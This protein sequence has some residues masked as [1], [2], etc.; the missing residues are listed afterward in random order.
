M[1]SRYAAFS[2]TTAPGVVAGREKSSDFTVRF[3]PP[4]TLAGKSADVKGSDELQ[5]DWS[6]ALVS[7]SGFNTIPNISA[8]LYNNAIFSY[9]NGGPT[10]NV[11]F[12]TG[13]YSITQINALIGASLL[14][15][16]FLAN[17]IV[18]TPNTSTGKIVITLA[19]GFTW[20]MTTSNFYQL[21]GFELSQAPITGA[22]S[23]TSN[24]QGN[25]NNGITA[26][27]LR[28]DIVMDSAINGR[29]SD[30][31]AIYQP[32]VPVGKSITLDIRNPIYLR[33][34]T[35]QQIQSMRLYVTDDQGR[36]VDYNG[37]DYKTNGTV[38]GVEFKRIAKKLY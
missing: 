31:L 38:W 2:S 29:Q 22:A 15:N 35:N 6:V 36:P 8:T 26:F 16:T 33:C 37:S 7:W 1:I 14:A 19:A 10:I 9:S 18:F 13:I 17:D 21:M 3:D 4:L 24:L 28:S 25:L 23:I 5:Q 12:P 34:K 32:N 27:Y 20:D 30:V 11:T